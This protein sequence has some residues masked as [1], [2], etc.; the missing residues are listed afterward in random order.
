MK[1]KS[2]FKKNANDILTHTLKEQGITLIALMVTIIIMLVLAG[3]TLNLALGDGGLINT[4]QKGIEEYEKASQKEKEDLEDV[5]EFIND[6]LMQGPNG[7]PL[8]KTVT[9]TVHETVKG[10]DKLGNPVV[11]PG[12]FKFVGKEDDTVEDGI[13]IQDDEGNEFVWIPVSNIDGDNNAETEPE[14]TDLIKLKDGSKVEITLGRYTF[15]N[16]SRNIGSADL[17]DGTP[18]IIQKGSERASDDSKFVIQTYY[19]ESTNLLRENGGEG[20]KSLENFI[21]SVETNHGYYLA[22]YEAGQ[23][24]DGKPVSKVG[25]AWTGITQQVASEAAQRMYEGEEKYASDLVN[26]YAWDTAIVFIEKMED[27]NYANANRETTGN[28]SLLNTGETNDVKCNIYDMAANVREWTTEYSTTSTEDEP[29]PCVNRGGLH[30]RND[31][32]TAYRFRSKTI[33]RYT[34]QVGFR[35]LLYLK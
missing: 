13:V 3:V 20:A 4:A 31:G 11:I 9:G 15:R 26:S 19:K 28:T 7:K 6:Y 8:P 23:G 22:R 34:N 18:E 16:A 1:A 29:R 33:E 35:P 32:F 17:P 24:T 2:T 25:I 12:G 5:T 30:D 27:A 21:T 10:E 14:A